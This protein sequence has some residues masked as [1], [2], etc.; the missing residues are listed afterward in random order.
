MNP[1]LQQRV[2]MSSWR[3][4]LNIVPSINRQQ[5]KFS[6]CEV[7]SCTHEQGAPCNYD[8]SLYWSFNPTLMQTFLLENIV[9]NGVNFY[10]H[11]A[12]CGRCKHCEL[13]NTAHSKLRKAINDMDFNVIAALLEQKPCVT[14]TMS[15]LFCRSIRMPHPRRANNILGVLSENELCRALAVSSWNEDKKGNFH[16]TMA[17]EM[18]KVMDFHWVPNKLKLLLLKRLRNMHPVL[19][20]RTS[21]ITGLYRYVNPLHWALSRMGF[22]DAKKQRKAEAKKIIKN[23]YH[24][25]CVEVVKRNKSLMEQQLAAEYQRI[26]DFM[27]LEFERKYDRDE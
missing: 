3:Q 16:I 9:G 25:M 10:V 2:S 6:F 11:R 1:N 14:C 4:V 7:N 27:E 17:K 15:P 12:V 23:F 19:F 5:F 18:L 22:D 21:R 26:N 13:C 8:D 20:M 24:S